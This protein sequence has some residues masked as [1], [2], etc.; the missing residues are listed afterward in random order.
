M[1]KRN[2]SQNMKHAISVECPRNLY[3]VV[4][5]ETDGSFKIVLLFFYNFVLETLFQTSMN[6]RCI[7]V[8]LHRVNFD[9]SKLFSR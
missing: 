6:E 2:L 7:N 3:F 8:V 1:F 4:L 5:C 9:K